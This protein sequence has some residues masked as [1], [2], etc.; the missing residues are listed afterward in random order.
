[1]LHEIVEK[2]FVKLLLHAFIHNLSTYPPRKNVLQTGVY[3]MGTHDL[4]RGS[5]C[6]FKKNKFNFIQQAL[7]CG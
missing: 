5:A 4:M 3:D 2:Y 6:S 7:A 1:M